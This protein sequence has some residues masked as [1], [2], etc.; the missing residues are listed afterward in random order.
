[1][2]VSRF[3]I[4]LGPVE[5]QITKYTLTASRVCGSI[6]RDGPLGNWHTDG[7]PTG[8]PAKARWRSWASM[9]SFQAS[10]TIEYFSSEMICQGVFVNTMASMNLFAT[11]KVAFW[12]WGTLWSPPAFG[13]GTFWSPTALW[14]RSACTTSDSRDMLM[15]DFWRLSNGGAIAPAG[16]RRFGSGA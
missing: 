12:C 7:V 1:M 3:S 8:A 14:S 6:I 13:W 15:T 10:S 2:Y 5:E 4:I 9:A 11:S 16:C